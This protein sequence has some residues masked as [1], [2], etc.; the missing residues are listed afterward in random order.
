[1]TKLW[2]RS[3]KPS[4]KRAL[5]VLA[6]ALVLFAVLDFAV[7][8]LMDSAGQV[9]ATLPV[10]EK[11]LVKYQSRVALAGTQELDRDTL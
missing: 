1:M 4:E 11:T 6:G 10:R 7:L 2:G 8:P 9:R 5:Q 3:L